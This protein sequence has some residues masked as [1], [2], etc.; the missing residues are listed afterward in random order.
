V[1]PQVIEYEDPETLQTEMYADGLSAKATDL[2]GAEAS[3][4]YAS[5]APGTEVGLFRDTNGDGVADVVDEALP[6]NLVEPSIVNSPLVDGMKYILVAGSIGASVQIVT[7]NPDD[8]VSEVLSTMML[9]NGSASV[10]L[11]TPLGEEARVQ[12]RDTTNS[13]YGLVETVGTATLHI[14]P[15]TTGPVAIDVTEVTTLVLKG[16]NLDRVETVVLHHESSG[17]APQSLTFTVSADGRSI[18]IDVPALPETWEGVGFLDISEGDIDDDELPFAIITC[19]VCAVE[20]GGG[21][22]GG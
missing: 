3:G 14:D 5:A 6:T 9:E 19:Q 8:T 13:L 18:T 20:D 1:E 22:S 15:T 12:A 21:S 4:V 17:L 2:S 7:L 16:A 11:A 10:T